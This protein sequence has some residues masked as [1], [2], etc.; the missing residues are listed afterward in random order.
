MHVI[1][2]R[3]NLKEG[4]VIVSSARKEN[5]QLPILKNILVE[6]KDSKLRISATDLE[7][8]IIHSVSAK[9]IKEGS[10]IVPF[11]VFQQIVQNLNSERVELEIEG[12]TLHVSTDNYNAKIG[13]SPRDEFPIIPQLPATAPKQF[14]VDPAVFIHALQICSIACQISEFRPEL[15]GVLFS[16]RD[17]QMQI[18]ATDSFR[19][20]RVIIPKKKVT[21]SPS[22]A[23]AIIIPL[24]TIQEVIRIF[25]GS[26]NA[27]QVLFDEGQI[28]F[29]NEA[30]ELI[31]RLIEGKFPDYDMII[32]KS[33]ESDI[34]LQKNELINA[35]KLTSSL[36]N[37]LNEIRIKVDDSLKSLQLLSSSHEYGESEYLLSCKAKG[38][39]LTISYNWKFLL[40]GL[41]NVQSEDVFIGINSEHKPS[42]ICTPEDESFLYILTSIKAA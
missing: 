24:R 11:S 16:M 14:S 31:S 28:V 29:K 32:P 17:E 8:G 41:K 25:Q 3:S 39:P 19:L 6:A 27:I 21:I 38:L 18:V 40:D 12:S 2:L 35:L 9:I 30:T 1:A 37:R 34:L 20:A 42:L 10:V 5:S 4:L 36:S 7:I 13:V 23:D 15:S 26:Q 33:F 22:I